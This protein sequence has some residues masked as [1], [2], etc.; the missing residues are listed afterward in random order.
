MINE[1][2]ILGFFSLV[3]ALHSYCRNKKYKTDFFK[4]TFF[5]ENMNMAVEET[6]V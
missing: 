3:L 6:S 4:M 5:T 2:L 1:I